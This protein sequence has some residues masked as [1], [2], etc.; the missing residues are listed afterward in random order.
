MIGNRTQTST[1]ISDRAS[2]AIGGFRDCADDK[3]NFG[4]TFRGNGNFWRC[5]GIDCCWRHGL[6]RRNKRG[7]PKQIK[8]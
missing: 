6:A 8:M 5:C 7:K 3:V 2:R 1:S 4:L